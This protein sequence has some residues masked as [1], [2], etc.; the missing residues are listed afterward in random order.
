MYAR[1]LET[2][3]VYLRA[4]DKAT[5]DVGEEDHLTP[6]VGHVPVLLEDELCGFFRDEVGGSYSYHEVTAAEREWWDARP[7]KRSS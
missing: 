4:L 5:A 3:L 1:F 7:W 2:L 6:Y